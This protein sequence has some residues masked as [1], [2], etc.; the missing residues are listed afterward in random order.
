MTLLFLKYN[1]LSP[2]CHSHLFLPNHP[3]LTWLV[4]SLCNIRRGK[5]AHHV[6]NDLR[7]EASDDQRP[8]IG[9]L[10][11]VHVCTTNAMLHLGLLFTG[12]L[13]P[14][15]LYQYMHENVHIHCAIFGMHGLYSTCLSTPLIS[16]QQCWMATVVHYVMQAC[17]CSPTTCMAVGCSCVLHEV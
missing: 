11:S 2:H 10:E 4:V 16:L 15:V 5:I 1:T 17:M 12:S 6:T 13:V 3:L 14:Y 8:V 7:P 9:R